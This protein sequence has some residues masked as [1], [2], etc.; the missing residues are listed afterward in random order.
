MTPRFIPLLLLLALSAFAEQAVLLEDGFQSMNP[1]PLFDVVGAHAEYHYY[2]ICDPK[3]VWS[4]AT[5]LS[6]DLSQRAWR[7][8]RE[9][10]RSVLAQ[11]FSNTKSKEFHPMLSAGDSLWTDYRV[12]T[13]FAP[14]SKQGRCGLAVRYKNNRCYYFAGV[15]GDRA[16]LLLVR[17]GV[18]FREPFE[19]VLAEK[20]FEWE[21][22]QELT[23]SVEASG[24]SIRMDLNGAVRLEAHDA[25]FPE[26]KI[27]LV[28]DDSA[29]F[30]SVRVTAEEE[31]AK[32]SAERIRARESEEEALQTA[33]PL[34]IVWKKV[35]TNGFGVG[36]NIRFG[37]LNGD[38]EVDLLIGQV[39]HH[40]PKDRNSELSC[41]TALTL[42]GKKLWQLGEP[43]PWKS[44]LTNDVAFQIHD[45]DGDGK[46]EVLYCMNMELVVAEGATGA[47]LRKV[48]TPETPKNTFPPYNKFPRILG[49]ALFFCDLR[50]V[51]RATDM[52]LKDR[53]QTAWALN[54]DLETLWVIQCNT[55]HYPYAADVDGDGKD[56]VAIGYSLLD[57]NGK[58]L[59]SHDGGIKDHADGVA[60]VRLEDKPDA[61]MR[62]LCAASDEGFFL[63]DMA[64]KILKHHYFGHIQNPAVA[65]FRPDLPGLE[66]VSVNYW[67]NQGIIR[68]YDSSGEQLHSFEPFSH[69]SLCLPVNWTGAPGELVALSANS[70]DGGLFDGWGRRAVRL[71]ADGHPDRCYDVLDVTGDCRD[72]VIVW[73]P[74]ELWIYT[75]SDSPKPGRLYKPK[76]NPPCN[77]SNYFTMVSQPGWSEMEK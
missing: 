18:G 26:G 4:V 47:T 22:K 61:E 28:S 71:P 60:L 46:N 37:D 8:L 15:A 12:G 32:R 38:G 75:Q 24:D 13:V 77:N 59:W 27:A 67:G 74:Y 66:T 25:C 70:E 2:P 54:S 50:G 52:I 44:E 10:G 43:D 40:G 57:D 16:V 33:N 58:A 36:R 29:R 65:D 64:G 14:E 20:P 9:G 35:K 6:D 72:E 56:E 53:Y 5:Y 30:F 73:D 3:G 68:F 7:I 1:G 55:G 76:R 41:L 21:P 42:A 19:Q 23:L 48:P 51:G 63:A 39:V 11:T 49:D 31:T 34:P 62:F 17:E 45:L 69:G